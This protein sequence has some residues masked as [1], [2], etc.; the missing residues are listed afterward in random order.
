MWRAINPTTASSPSISPSGLAI[1]A[2]RMASPT[3]SATITPIANARWAMRPGHSDRLRKQLARA[4]TAFGAVAR[5]NQ[6]CAI[7]ISAQDDYLFFA[8]QVQEPQA[9]P[10]APEMG[11]PRHV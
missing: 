10:T 6:Q 5:P 4:G 11:L 8:A 2:T 3:R 9:L 7:E 1:T